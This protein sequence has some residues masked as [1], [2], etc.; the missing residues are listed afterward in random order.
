MSKTFI[1]KEVVRRKSAFCG[2]CLNQIQI[3]EKAIIL[4]CNTHY[5]IISELEPHVVGVFHNEC[6][7][8]FLKEET[9]TI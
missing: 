9:N 5:D 1:K 6:V 2:H 3:G 4:K 7:E 8:I